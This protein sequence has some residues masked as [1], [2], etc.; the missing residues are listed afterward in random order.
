MT[1][2]TM[3]HIYGTASRN[4]ISISMVPTFHATREASPVCEYHQRKLFSIES[5]N[6]LRS[7]VR[8]IRKPHLACLLCYLRTDHPQCIPYDTPH[9]LSVLH[10]QEINQTDSCTNTEDPILF[11][12]E[13]VS[14]TTTCTEQ[15]RCFQYVIRK[16]KRKGALFY[17]P[18]D[19]TDASDLH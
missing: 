19:F 18:V 4:F 5:L 12:L 7:L 2:V 8:R 10:G 14:Q 11:T 15:K 9:V 1:F 6:C 13:F 17:S 3:L 16:Q